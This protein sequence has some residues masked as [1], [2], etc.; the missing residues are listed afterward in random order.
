MVDVARCE[1]A[2]DGINAALPAAREKVA[3][4]VAAALA[5]ER[6]GGK[7][8][9]GGSVLL[10]DASEGVVTDHHA[11]VSEVRSR[12]RPPPPPPATSP[13][14]HSPFPTHR[15]QVVP[16]ADGDELRLKFQAGDF[17]QNNPFALPALVDYVV[18][19]ASARAP[20][21]RRRGHAQRRA[22]RARCGRGT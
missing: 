13:L 19:Q 9:L 18:A 15:A 22:A 12:R 11:W 8:A 6:R 10:R 17:F 16:L 4:S 1:I 20:P 3:E 2:T 14:T 21:A 5:A 7:R